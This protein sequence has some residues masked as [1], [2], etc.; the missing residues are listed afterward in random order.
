MTTRPGGVGGADDEVRL[1]CETLVDI[2]GWDQMYENPGFTT[3]LER[4][5]VPMPD[6]GL[7]LP[8][9]QDSLLW[10]LPDWQIEHDINGSRAERGG[11]TLVI[12]PARD[13]FDLA[14]TLTDGSVRHSHTAASHGLVLRAVTA[15]AAECD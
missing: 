13:G 15:M 10:S 6:S 7:E 9:V 12:S 11:A 14:L 5:E 2:T 4:R 3:I 8:V 1:G